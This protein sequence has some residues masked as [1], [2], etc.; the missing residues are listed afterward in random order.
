[1]LFFAYLV[2]TAQAGDILRGGATSANGRMA[3]DARA[4][5]GAQAA[6]I[7]R[8][9]AADRLARTTKAINDMRQ[10]QSSARAAGS[11]L[12]V[13]DGL[14]TGGLERLPGGKWTG[15]NA[16]TQS[17][18]IVNIKQLKSQAL[19]DWKTF[20]VGKNTTLNFDQSAG[21]NDSGKWIAF[22]K[23]FD[24]SGVPSKIL[25]KINADGQ[26]Y[27]INQNGIIFGGSSQVNTRTLVASSLPIN[28]NLISS[29]LL[30]NKDAQFLFSALPISGGADGTSAFVPDAPL[31]PDG[32]VGNIVVQKGAMISGPVSAD[33]NGG[34]VILV[35]ANVENEGTISTPSGQTILAAGLQL[36][37]RAHAQS[38]PSLRGLDVW[39]GNVG[40]YGGSVTN[41]GYIES[42]TGSTI[43]AG[44]EINQS[45]IVESS[46]SVSLNGRIDLIASYGAVANPN[47]DNAAATGGGGPP[48]LSQFT[49]TVNFGPGSVTR[50][51]PD[52]SSPKTIPG[53]SLPE[54]SRVNVE[55]FTIHMQNGSVLLAPN[56]N[57]NF[58]AGIWP[59]KDVDDNR[60]I[61]LADGTTAEPELA[62][63]ISGSSQRFAFTGGQTYFDSGSLLDISG[64]TAV[65]V[66]MAQSILTVQLRGSELADSPLQRSSIL[67]GQ[68]L[69]VDIRKNGTY[70]GFYWVGTPLG[71]LT[72]AA[73][74]I[75]RNVAQLTA[76]GGRLSIQSG[77]S[78]I[79][80]NG[81]TLDVSG[82]YF[83]NEAGRI[84]TSRVLRGGNLV[85]IAKATPDM[86]YNSTYQ[87]TSTAS[88]TKWGITNLYQAALAPLGAYNSG[89]F[90]TGA[91]GGSISLIAPSL[92]IA[93]DLVGQTITGPRQ[94]DSPAAS[95]SLSISFLAEKR[96]GIAGT[97]FQIV[98]ASPYA[99]TVNFV[100]G[101]AQVSAPE[102]SIAYGSADALP[103]DLR[104]T[105]SIGTSIYE[106]GAGGFG[107]VTIDNRDG[108]VVVAPGTRILTPAG[109]G[110][111]VRAA[112]VFVRGDVLAPGGFLSFTA[113]NY[114]PFLY[115][116]LNATGGL[117]GVAAPLP[118]AGRGVISLAQGKQLDVSGMLIDERS[119]AA[120]PF[121]MT[122]SLN[123]GSVTLEGYT[124][125]LEQH[126]RIDASGGA[127]AK[128][129][130][131]YIY[132]T[133]GSISLLAGKDPVLA[134]T[135]G[136][137]LTLGGSLS[138]YSATTGGKLAI[139]ANLIQIGGSSTDPST[140]VFQPK[141]FRRG[142][143]TSYSLTGIGKASKT[144]GEYIP[145]VRI[146]AGTVVAP[147]AE[148]LV[149]ASYQQSG[150]GFHLYPTLSPQGLRQPASL[151]LKGIGADDSFTEDVLEVRG[152]VIVE[153]GA[154]IITD[155]LGSV[156]LS[157]DTVT[158]LG[159]IIA[160]AGKITVAGK[161]EFR[162][163]KLLKDSATNALPTVFLG[164]DSQLL[165]TGTTVL[166]PDPY[167][168][169]QGNVYS[170]GTILVSGNILADKGAVLD[171]SGTSGI[172]DLD[173][174]LAATDSAA[175]PSAR[176]GLNQKP[177]AMRGVAT[178]VDSN[179]GTISLEGSQMLLSD[180]T[181][182]G[183]AG[184]PTA[185]GGLLAVSSGRFYPSG[186]QKT[187]ADINLTVTQS[188]Q[189]IASN[190]SAPGVGIPVLNSG[191]GI[192][193]GQG[194]FSLASFRAGG[195][196][197]L[198]LG[199]KYT[200][201][202]D[203]P[204]GGNV[205]FQGPITINA[206]GALRVA[207]GGVIVSD[208]AVSLSAPYIAI[209]QAF[210]PPL[211]PSDQFIPFEQNP[212]GP[213]GSSAYHPKPT[214]GAGSVT[215]N[216][217][218]IDLGTLVLQNTGKLEL[219][220]IGGDIRG[221]GVVSVAGNIILRAGQVYPTTLGTFDIFAYDYTAGGI[222][223][224]GSVK[225]IAAGNRPLP[226]S[227]AGT[228]R[229]FA[230]NITQAGNLRAPFGSIVLGWDGTDFIPSTPAFDRPIDA[231]AG[232]TQTVPTTQTVVLTSGSTTSVS[233]VDP[234][235]GQEIIVPFGL[236]PDGLSWID[237]SGVNIT[238]SG[239]TAKR[240]AIGANNVTT[241]AGSLV[242]LRGGG[243]LLAYRWVAGTGGSRDLFGEA[244][245]VW[246]ASTKYSAADL[247][248]YGGKTWSARV[249]IDPI[250]L[251][252]SPVPT[253]GLY[254]SEVPKSYAVLPG[255]GFNYSPY[256]AFNTGANAGDLGGEPGYVSSSLSVGD[257]I[258][259]NGTPGLSAGYYT[260][261]PKRYALLP[262][263][264]MITPKS[265]SANGE[266]T[267]AEGASYTTGYRLNSYNPTIQTPA[268][269]SLFEVAPPN[270]VSA[271][272]SYDI[273][274]ANSFM[275][276]AAQR[277]NQNSTQ[278][279]PADAGYLA[280]QGN[281]GL[282]LYGNVLAAA[283]STGRGA[284]ADVSSASDMYVIGGSG[285]APSGATVVLNEGVLKSWGIESL[286][287]GGL[288]RSTATGTSLD[289][290]S[291]SVTVSNAGSSFSG[292]EILLAARQFVT[293]DAGSSVESSG[294][295]SASASPLSI[296]GDGALLWVSGSSGIASTRTGV[297]SSTAPRLTIG[298][299]AKISGTGVIADSS[300]GSDFDPS[301]GI[302]AT[303][304][305]LNSGQVSIL[306]QPQAG[307][308]PGAAVTPQLVLSGTLLAQ[309]QSAEQLTIGSYRSIDIYGA[310]NFGST[311]LRHLTFRAGGD[312]PL[313]SA[314]EFGIRGFNQ[315][316]G[317]ALF[318]A[319]SV[320]FENPS[321]AVGLTAPAGPLS[322]EFRV[323]AGTVRFGVNRFGIAGYAAVNLVTTGGA[324]TEGVGTFASAGDL[325]ITAPLIAG[326][327]GSNYSLVAD[328]A[329][330]MLASS[331][332]A[333]VAS[334]LGAT[335]AMSGTS[336]TADS[337]I[338]LPSGLVSLT[339]L[340]GDVAVGGQIDVSG[341]SQTF[342]DL[343]R[344]ADAGIVNISAG[345]GRV[346]LQ[347][348]SL[349][350]VSAAAGG[351]SAGTL[352]IY[353]QGPFESLGTLLGK[354]PTA[355][356]V[357]GNGGA[358]LL[359][360]GSLTSFDDLASQLDVGGFTEER[361]LRIR[362]G[363][364]TVSGINVSR[365]FTLS[366]DTGS[367][368]VVGTIDAH[369]KTGGEIN[370]IAHESITL[371]ANSKL[372]AHGEVFDNAGKGG[373]IS[374]E[375]GSATNG[376]VS[377]TALL[378]IKMDS[379]IDLSVGSFVAGDYATPGS[380]A[381]NGQ[382]AGTLHLRAPQRTTG[383]GLGVAVSEL[384]D[385]IIGASSILVEGY[386]I[387]NVS[388]ATGQITGT[389]STFNGLPGTS[390]AAGTTQ[391]LVYDNGVQFLGTAGTTT[392]GY[393]AMKDAL[394]G[395]GDPN[396]LSSL[397]V[398][399]PGA[400]ISNTTPNGD[401]SLGSSSTIWSSDW[402][403]GDFR[404]GPKAAAGVLTL[405]AS[406][407]IV[408]WNTLSDG[409]TAVNPT[410]TNGN[411]SMWLA[412]L[413]GLNE[414]LP[415]NAQSWSY[416]IAAGSDLS[417][418]DF[419]S[420]LRPDKLAADKGSVLLGR[421][422]QA[423]PN[424]A[425]S[426]AGV[427][428]GPD[429][430]TANSIRVST[431]G[432]NTGTRYQ[433]I[434]TGTGDI[435][436][437]AGRDVQLRNQFASIYTAGVRIPTPTKIYSAGDFV[438][439]VV[440]VN[441]NF[442][443]DQGSL[444][445]VQQRYIAQWSL[446]GG[447][448]QI[449]AG[450]NIGRYTQDGSGNLIVDSS[451]QLPGNWLYRRGYDDPGTGAAGV[452]TTAEGF[453]TDTAASTAWWID[454]S[455]FF[456]GF[457]TL[458]GG[459][460]ALVAGHDIVNADAVAPTNA[461]M[462]GTDGVNNIAPDSSKLLEYGG[463][464]VLVKAGNNID[465]GVYYVEGGHGVLSAGGSV[466]TNAA[467]SPSFGIL[468][469]SSL[470]SE[471]DSIIQSR[472]PEVYD[473]STWLPTT[474][475]LGKGAF[476]VSARSDVV[477]G[478][479]V[480]A[481]LMPQGLNNKF[482]YKTYFNTYSS[483]SSVNVTSVG[484]S[485]THRLAE[486]L[487]YE[488]AATPVLI[489][490]MNKQNSYDIN[491]Q[492]RS[493]YWQPWAR[494][495]ETDVTAFA[496]ATSVAP[497]I[498]RSSSFSGDLNIVGKMNLFPSA[499][500]TIELAASGGV[501]GLQPTGL[502]RNNA[503]GD[504]KAWST[505]M[506]NL[507]DADPA[508]IYGVTSPLGYYGVTP[509]IDELNKTSKAVFANFDQV[510]TESGSF[511]GSD[512]G[513]DIIRARHAT[514]PIH[515][516]DLNPVRIYAGS[517]D[518]TGLT[519]YSSKAAQISAFQDITDVSFYIQ[520]VNSQ[521]VS[522]VSAGRDVLPYNANAPLRALASN[523][524]LGNIVV[525][526][527][528]QTVL[529][530]Q[531]SILPGDIQIGG[532]GAA[533][534]LAGRNVDLGTGENFSN[535][536]GTGITSIGNAKNPFL[537][538]DGARLLVFAG[539]GGKSGGAALGMVDSDLVFASLPGSG[540]GGQGV[541]AV[542][543]GAITELDTFFE[544][545]KQTGLDYA[546]TQS[547]ANG[548]A[549]IEAL[550]GAT[551]RTGEIFTRARD[552]RTTNGGAIS[553]AA[554]N[555]GLTLASD[556]FG[557]PLTPPGVVTEYGGA[558]SIFTNGSVDIGRARIFTLR[559]GDITIW[560]STGD[561]AAGTSPKTVVTAPPTRV[562]IDSTSADIATDLGGLATGGGIGVLASVEG[563]APGDV[564]LVAPVGTVDAGDAGIQATGNLAIAAA[565]VLNASNISAGGTAAG[566]PTTPTVSAPNVAGL[567][568]GAAANSAANSAA[569]NVADQARQNAQ[570]AED[571]PSI[572]TVEVL[573]YGGGD[574]DEG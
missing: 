297:T 45:G 161:S 94:L 67:R 22:N 495:A 355:A 385:E 483:D 37:I 242:D 374:I 247:V 210:R 569:S 444:G 223:Q 563:I 309:A 361:N 150:D 373:S 491:S 457:G 377:P 419:H 159:S 443:P 207:G 372:D 224:Q 252:S 106:A 528:Q 397:L 174:V 527:T 199:Y 285:S 278:R 327:A 395:A 92:V 179:G 307:A 34:R 350:S 283:A 6:E 15:A 181:L 200:T 9:K 459:N 542:E 446:A 10:M 548:F 421:F 299:G 500:G 558:I 398:I 432:A 353:S 429:G 534:V 180:A 270:V 501:I 494:L 42:L 83:R 86:V 284:S 489:A 103:A 3:A 545:L 100:S 77:G 109:G 380:S 172:L 387:F 573:G 503:S 438:T 231:V 460:I 220:A 439:P 410:S 330:N 466:T 154:S 17:G 72:G 348:D 371:E 70:N 312:D 110:L 185:T 520:N 133:G 47:F 549:A 345:S 84:L 253:I 368:D 144:P 392:A 306:L 143:F 311:L 574:S 351:G 375:A 250:A 258:Y 127:R 248:S 469:A 344:Y 426:G 422:Y 130:G 175:T 518:I 509:S 101:K 346:S 539:V 420:V 177:W 430:L 287:I 470:P 173:P 16:P 401:I 453:V 218:L 206:R 115:A 132:G 331:G 33:G 423:I 513:I 233:G 313:T 105:F 300:Y 50:I 137:D 27:V 482:W 95:S 310:G 290:R 121:D 219:N 454:F 535:G 502:T 424:S 214:Y 433:V 347:A 531:V 406:G 151:T 537:P 536:T 58:R 36:G 288:R 403:L 493:T 411:S 412:Q 532:G 523:I 196:D 139:Q 303:A 415:A 213:D 60:T 268:T 481:F 136:G 546:T 98:D 57:V 356:G 162:L 190:N 171:V 141:F 512:A 363:D 463:G 123:G 386:K 565:A 99:P 152:D 428:L 26:V 281:A 566:V 508:S 254:W 193:S 571:A 544:T 320:A 7:A 260:L 265:N 547:Y 308:L 504:L 56:A 71:D 235:T 222:A 20:N 240:I 69:V 269:R 49:G 559:G 484:G 114:S 552:I 474:L 138:A 276:E 272:S 237:P 79:V 475:Y 567:T 227:A 381:F 393:T 367:I 480:N 445:A 295:L 496:T 407:N 384:R 294:A 316:T 293:A 332:Q 304:L 402:N 8:I 40:A 296:I 261:L 221:N 530:R 163:P 124:V 82:G 556:I 48:F 425:T 30:N 93:G 358:F 217:Q 243:D 66:P 107:V 396:G 246:N 241:E 212:P 376:V 334:G 473:P 112:N 102:F 216:A 529:G 417:A 39:V 405:R 75:Q 499:T 485:I 434:R 147:V 479:V 166:T 292:P 365:R 78:I 4:N 198:D 215:L 349:V 514:T 28:L 533:E 394:L 382:F 541:G 41:K 255:Y 409:F 169:R 259:L 321:A 225:I 486:T 51:L 165:A 471:A 65:F 118:V 329:L 359:D 29:G 442:H 301:A 557:N 62:S 336:I 266:H 209:G 54:N 53:T 451:H 81:A 452:I 302:K 522:I 497:P 11:A 339:A 236:S 43:L 431:T 263:A 145:A 328:G 238:L 148:Q 146:V 167:G 23:V 352:A 125:S 113:Y 157:G 64:S 205:Q 80:Q 506:I 186:A 391:R 468:S 399:A 203:V 461:R 418:V 333:T 543:A 275:P 134:T 226:F 553:M 251:G 74:I 437:N 448:V 104:T 202:G 357:A 153:K 55:G 472:N 244:G 249:S 245:S 323:Q 271:R 464:D 568:S 467:R 122:R 414:T 478:P 12:T 131:G 554:P 325:N 404:F 390:L 25:G 436:I 277:A 120:Q 32:K 89:E 14:V 298:A 516:G 195:F 73:A 230:S 564:A 416:R 61:F 87:G 68:P 449:S 477:L 314:S 208:A 88:S 526:P 341:Y 46:T 168:R 342:Y 19:L 362:T 187:G 85:D 116:E 262:G 521:S 324:L 282:R 90:I 476:D 289:V 335:L 111:I 229:I 505:G 91:A 540:T 149:V 498:L 108:D 96:L 322:G 182:L 338:V 383:S 188:G 257:R 264:Y 360:A 142:G 440:S 183:F 160:P 427:A 191:G 129:L 551:D 211:N 140:L 5:A 326:A 76:Q 228:I 31:T 97:P 256:G 364:V 458:G 178:K 126:S 204:Y 286:L 201:S 462:P 317:T 197:S 13:P 519:L 184:G 538:F 176:S 194:F 388:G 507:S 379:V 1:M 38:D 279:L 117:S 492:N 487:P 570:P 450:R 232:S 189:V 517:G 340:T 35:G 488:S 315:G 164:P 524:A 156:N 447:N 291:N 21:G 455:N 135:I 561:I 465:G 44:K 59:Y 366:T 337:R 170:G 354:A 158:V 408:F 550:F 192:I 319:D 155:P 119:T 369:G 128:P 562:L 24:P 274:S 18:G 52:Y 441:P 560:S 490:W 555:G 63:S 389:R 267:T 511:S 435:E 413:M 370:L 525:D 239:L 305:T 273:F 515:S 400:E 343:T 510:F 378:D 572:I 2:P 318:V 234:S 456:E 280:I